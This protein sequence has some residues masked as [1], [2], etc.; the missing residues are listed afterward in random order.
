MNDIK[1]F[2]N[3]DI[4]ND[5]DEACEATA[6]DKE[7]CMAKDVVENGGEYSYKKVNGKVIDV[8]RTEPILVLHITTSFGKR[9]TC[10]TVEELE[11]YIDNVKAEKKLK[12]DEDVDVMIGFGR[13]TQAAYDKRPACKYFIKT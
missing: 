3:P 12:R 5:C 1:S 8:H 13:M 2:M 6:E 7:R 10:R 9:Y 11:A 4:C